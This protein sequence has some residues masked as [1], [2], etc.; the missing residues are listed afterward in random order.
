MGNLIKKQIKENYIIKDE[1]ADYYRMKGMGPYMVD[2]FGRKYLKPS[3]GY[4]LER[5]PYL[6]R[7]YD[8]PRNYY[9]SY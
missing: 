2:S 3:F 5:Y 4:S 8:I 9:L 1:E 7:E 6:Y